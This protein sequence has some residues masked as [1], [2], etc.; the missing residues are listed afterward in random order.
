VQVTALTTTPGGQIS[1]GG[2]WSL[3][4]PVG[5]PPQRS[6]RKTVYF[7][8]ATAGADRVL[9]NEAGTSV[10]GE[11]QPLE[12][13]YLGSA[14]TPPAGRVA[15]D[16]RT[17]IVDLHE[18][19]E[20][21]KIDLGPGKSGFTLHRLDEKKIA[22]ETTSGASG[23]FLAEPIADA[24]FAVRVADSLT[25]SQ[26]TGV[27]VRGFPTMVRLGVA[28]AGDLA[29]PSFFWRNPGEVRDWKDI[30][31]GKPFAVEL[32]RYLD[33]LERPLGDFEDVALVL[34]SDGP[35][36]FYPYAVVINYA[37]ERQGFAP[38]D[39]EK[40]V[41]QFGGRSLDSLNVEVELPTG[42]KVR[43][44]A[45]RTVES[46]GSDRPADGASGQVSKERGF[47][48]DAEKWTAAPVEPAEPVVASGISL[49][50]VALADATA[51]AV[52]LRE[53]WQGA[54][55]GRILA[56]G[57]ID[58][59]RAA[60]LVWA[61]LLLPA[62]V[63]L[64]GQTYWLAARAAKGAAVLLAD[65]GGKPLHRFFTAANGQVPPAALAV[66]SHTLMRCLDGEAVL[67]EL[68]PALEDAPGDGATLVF[69]AA[70]PG[71]VTVYAPIIEYDL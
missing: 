44:A 35:C 32:Q 6:F 49:A 50:L 10:W 40:R 65:A 24:R 20:I 61:T 26:V 17:V 19:R 1:P 67:Y 54:P 70:V 43:S 68:A 41:L 30:G 31:V 14:W 47:Y 63:T 60:E 7:R 8:L 48:I 18:P 23:S 42:A 13:D 55:S 4:A 57:A 2:L 12:V 66:G 64:F 62:D 5:S 15:L 11:F 37:L 9:V 69:S 28:P 39:A 16:S 25:P 29:S 51:L 59:P 34:E 71:Q 45:L 56:V 27:T 58:V 36:I 38:G 33:S 46:F 52:E 3:D 21:V 22:P 53:D